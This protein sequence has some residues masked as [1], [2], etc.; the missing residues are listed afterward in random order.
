MFVPDDTSHRCSLTWFVQRAPPESSANEGE[1]DRRSLVIIETSPF[2]QR[3]PPHPHPPPTN[4]STTPTILSSF[5]LQRLLVNSLDCLPLNSVH[6]HVTHL[7]GQEAILCKP[8]QGDS[9]LIYDVNLS[10]YL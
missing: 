3:S 5:I 4:T 9:R 2:C 10:T 7:S 6:P 8:G 1:L